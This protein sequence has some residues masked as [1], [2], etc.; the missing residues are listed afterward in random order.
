MLPGAIFARYY[1]FPY[2]NVLINFLLFSILIILVNCEL[3]NR[4][5]N[6][7]KLSWKLS[8]IS[9]LDSG[10]YSL[11]YET[12]EGVVSLQCKTVVLTIPSYVAS[13]LLRPLSVSFFLKRVLYHLF[14][15]INNCFICGIFLTW[16]IC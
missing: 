6:K 14:M 1:V 7:V 3:V 9:K 13:T 11:T 2:S 8:S 5:G 12:P 4:L 16:A 15:L 10:E